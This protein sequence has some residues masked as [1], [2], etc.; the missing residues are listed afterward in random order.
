MAKMILKRDKYK[1]ARG[2]Y[3]RLLNIFCRKCKNL[4]IVYQKDGRGSLLRMYFDRIFSPEE[5]VGLQKDNIKDIA[6]L[7]CK[8]CGEIIGTPYIYPLENRPAFRLYQDSTT[9]KIRKNS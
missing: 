9:K 2:G 5:L 7:K 6:I 1:S 3:S 4:I 8:K